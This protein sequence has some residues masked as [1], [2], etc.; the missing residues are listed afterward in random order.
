MMTALDECSLLT[1][2]G[3]YTKPHSVVVALVFL[4]FSKD[5]PDFPH[6]PPML[7]RVLHPVVYTCT[8]ILLLCLFT[9]IITHILHYRYCV[10]ARACVII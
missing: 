6:S 4:F 3:F 9:V 7:V 8:A 5:V 10:S 2:S 1:I